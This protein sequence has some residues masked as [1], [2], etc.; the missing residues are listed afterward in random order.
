MG[1][2]CD[3]PPADGDGDG[4]PDASDNCP[5]NANPDQADTDGD[6]IGDACDPLTDSDGDSIADASDNCPLIA[7]PDQADADN[8]GVGD[9]CDPL[10]D[11]DGDGVANALDNC[12]AVPNP[13]QTDTDGDG[14]GDACDPDD[15]NDGVLDDVDR[16]PGV[17]DDGDG[18]GLLSCYS[19]HKLLASD[20]ATSDNFSYYA[21]AVSGDT[22]VVGAYLDDDKG[23]NSGSAYVYRWNGGA[24][25]ETKLT[26]SDGAAG[27]YFGYAVAVSGDTVV[28]G[29]YLDDDKGANS[30][31]AYVYRWNGGAWVETKLTA[32]D[33]AAGDYF[34]YA[35]A[36]SGDTLV[37]GAY[38]DDDK[39]SRS[40]AAYVYR[41]N[42]SAWVQTKLTASDGAVNDIFGEAMAVSGDTVVVGAYGD[43]DKGTDSGAAYVY[44]WNGSAWVQ[45]K[46]TASDGAT[47]DYFGE[48]VAVSGDT[49]VVGAL[50]D[51]DKGAESGSAYVYRWNGGAWVETKLTASDGVAGDYFGHS[52]A[53]SGDTVVIGSAY[54]DD[55]GA[56]SGA[57]YVYRWNGSAWV[58]TKLTASDGAASDYFGDAVAASGGTLVVGAWGDDDLGGNAGAAYLFTTDNCPLDANPDQTNTDGDGFGDACDPDDDNDGDLD[59]ADNCPLVANSDQ[60][61]TDGD[62]LGDACDSST[63]WMVTG[64]ANSGPGS[65]RQA[66]TDAN[67]A[68]GTNTIDLTGATGIITLTG[69]PIAIADDVAITGPGASQLA[70][71][72]NNASPIFTVAAGATVTLDGLTL[73]N[74]HNTTSNGGAIVNDGVLTVTNSSL[75][76]N[77]ANVTGGAIANFG[78]LNVSYSILDS[79]VTSTGSGGAIYNCNVCTLSVANSTLS[80]NQSATSGGAI[81]SVASSIYPVA[82]TNSTLSGN[83][84]GLNGG[85]I[86]NNGANGGVLTITNST[87]SGNRADGGN[88][89][90]I[91][92]TSAG[93]LNITN[94]TLTGNSL[95]TTYNGGGISNT[96]TLNIGNSLVAG[97]TLL[98]PGEG[99]EIFSSVNI[100]SQGNNLFGESGK[101]GLMNVTTLVNSDIL[102]G[103]PQSKPLNQ[104]I[105]S[106]AANGGPTQTHLLAPGSPAINA[107]AT[108]LAQAAGLTTD[109]RG[110]GYPRIVGGAVDIGAVE[111]DAAPPIVDADGDEVPD[112]NDNC[113]VVY[114]PDQRDQDGRQSRRPL[115]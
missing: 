95:P 48:A 83:I 75:L 106:L 49:V 72:G 112:A 87:L 1:D 105:G 54:D 19:Q 110:A 7:N 97:N 115:R 103:G 59:I 65:L 52:V 11:S 22:V 23:A 85:A 60:T 67:T 111:V 69:G 86:H 12:P 40:G 45:T 104:I 113:P 27:D 5:A 76:S 18:D 62:G 90:A 84:S 20:G 34:G 73:Q 24:W 108:A 114:N 55:K 58:Q 42:G 36:V 25:V 77:T 32:S 53:I 61:D 63:T 68:A 102:G 6:G 50:Y 30:G 21:V 2:V 44:R 26:A 64:T 89:G 41:W 71:S 4:V 43:D 78:T 88:G 80:R 94:C 35:V 8:D 39:G 38:E 51:D 79:N 109:Q 99:P 100:T 47:S 10:T 74:G 93:M 101:P 31:S 57:A 17:A 66:V 96:G 3:A 28:V 107:G 46:L 29:A 16:C 70:I 9:A 14:V 81:A 13:D 98:S 15:D 92:N 37:V 56:N 33:G 82:I 91:D